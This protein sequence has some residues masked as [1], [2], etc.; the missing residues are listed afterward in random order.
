MKKI[1]SILLIFIY[2]ITNAQTNENII[3][4]SPTVAE[5]G[6]YGVIPVSYYTGT[7]NIEI[8]IYNLQVGELTLPISLS[9]HAGGIKVD[10]IASWVGLGWSLNAGGI[11]NRTIKGENDFSH[12]RIDLV[13][14]TEILNR[15]YPNFN[16]IKAIAEHDER[17]KDGQPDIFNFNFASYSGQFVLNKTLDNA[18][19]LKQNKEL[20]LISQNTIKDLLNLLDHIY[21]TSFIFRDK[22]G[23]L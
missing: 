5:L 9:Y 10:Q 6:K 14:K 16:D 21:Q 4:S 8:P 19:F 17:H 23:V 1:L 22:Q 20:K 7:P 12:E 13:S 3:Q 18:F 11:I 15:E 2:I